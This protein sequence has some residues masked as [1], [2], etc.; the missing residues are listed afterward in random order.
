MNEECFILG[1]TTLTDSQLR[2]RGILPIRR[3][4][5]NS[6]RTYEVTVYGGVYVCVCVGAG[7]VSDPHTLG[8]ERVYTIG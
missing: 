4:M 8:G 2:H 6:Y 5:T 3:N 1:V 7:T